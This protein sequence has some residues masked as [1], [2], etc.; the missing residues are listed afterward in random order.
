MG[1]G[2]VIAPAP[3]AQEIAIEDALAP[4]RAQLEDPLVTDVFVNGSR[5]MFIDRGSGT[6]PVPDWTASEREVRE[7]A[8][9]LIAQGG[10]HVDDA[11]PCVDVRLRGGIRVH[12]VLAPIATA[13]TTLSIRIPRFAATTL[14]TLVQQGMIDHSLEMVLREAVARRANLLVSGAAGVGKTTL[15]SALLGEAPP[16]E[17]IVTIE[18]V[19]EIALDHPHHV[20]LESRQANL[21]GAGE[22]GLARLVREA[23]RMKPDRLV[24][25]ECR[26][27][28]VRELLSALNTGHDGGAGTVH[29]NSLA[30]VATRLEAL[31]A[32]AGLDETTLA[33]QVTSA[34]EFVI[35][36]ERDADGRRRVAAVGEFRI[37]DGRLFVVPKEVPHIPAPAVTRRSRRR[38]VAAAESPAQ[39]GAGARDATPR[40]EVPAAAGVSAV[41]GA[42]ADT[43]SGAAARAGAASGRGFVPPRTRVA[44]VRAERPPRAVDPD[45]GR[46][47]REAVARSHYTADGDWH[48]VAASSRDS[49]AITDTRPAASSTSAMSH[50][51]PRRIPDRSVGATEPALRRRRTTPEA[52][53]DPDST[54]GSEDAV[55]GVLPTFDQ[56]RERLRISPRSA[57][58]GPHD[59]PRTRGTS[60]RDG[61]LQDGGAQD[62]GSGENGLSGNS[63]RSHEGGSSFDR[64]SSLH[65]DSSPHRG[66]SLDRGSSFDRG[67]SPNRNGSED[68]DTPDDRGWSERSMRALRAPRTE[69]ALTSAELD[70]QW[71]RLVAGWDASATGDSEPDRGA[72]DNGGPARGAIG[73]GAPDRGTIGTGTTRRDDTGNGAIGHR[74]TDKGTTDRRAIGNGAIGHRITE[75]DTADNDTADYAVALPRP[76]EHV[77]PTP[78]R[79]RY[80]SGAWTFVPAP[81]VPATSESASDAGR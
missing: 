50:Q 34:I 28:E 68:G 56:W 31:G 7:L 23:L 44:E 76:K 53:S 17:R 12:A 62:E 69:P 8:S 16:T 46:P 22:V 47:A 40:S 64:D 58:A 81:S 26:G 59:S 20:A 5:G 79:E 57:P 25:G 65:R 52:S 42:G 60:P 6:E 13:G 19:A 51:T 74:A 10:R 78:A 3:K 61:G 36:L 2:F 21:E 73:N 63:G 54:A 70:A 77:V 49:L 71:A 4:F 80:R 11:H 1:P 43:H 14:A 24:I 48:R 55:R 37:V 66:A 29:A 38:A 72:I 15:L 27:A 30:D 41:G 18:D 33:R 45:D 39:A 9:E 32:L 35:H 67:I 75:N